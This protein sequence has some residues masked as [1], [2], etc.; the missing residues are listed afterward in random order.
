MPQ[1]ISPLKEMPTQKC[2]LCSEPMKHV[3]NIPRT[4]RGAEV[5]VFRC[6]ECALVTTET[7][8]LVARTWTRFSFS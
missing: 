2:D 1:P 7:F 6:D 3:G 4:P 5:R 8:D